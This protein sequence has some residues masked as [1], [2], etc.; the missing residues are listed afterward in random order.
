MRTGAS[1]CRGRL[2]GHR[3]RRVHLPRPHQR[4]HQ[5]ESERNPRE[6]GNDIEKAET[7]LRNEQRETREEL[8]SEIRENRDAIDALRLEMN[9]GFVRVNKRVDENED[10]S[11]QRIDAVNGRVDDV[12]G[13]NIDTNR[14]IDELSG[15][16]NS[17]NVS[18]D[19]EPSAGED[20][21]GS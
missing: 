18:A 13:L 20:A 7:E 14:R 12:N 11:T 4:R 6:L 5:R 16:I 19:D 1:H 3:D 21:S 2:G 8:R 17:R 9:E 10:E 15:R